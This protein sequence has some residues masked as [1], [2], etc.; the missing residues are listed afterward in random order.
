M[1]EKLMK[2]L[3]EN[4]LSDWK[5][6]GRLTCITNVVAYIEHDYTDEKQKMEVFLTKFFQRHPDDYKIRI[7]RVLEHLKRNDVLRDLGFSV[8]KFKPFD[9]FSFW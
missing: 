1:D 2:I 9:L 3:I 8:G 6:F 7:I 4:L 5:R